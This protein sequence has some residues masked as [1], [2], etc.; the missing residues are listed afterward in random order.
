MVGQGRPV[1]TTVHEHAGEFTA[2][3]SVNNE[4]D[5]QDRQGV[6]SN[7]AGTF[8]HQYYQQ[9]GHDQVCLVGIAG[10]F[11]YA[12]IIMPDVEGDC[13]TEQGQ[14]PVNNRRFGVIGTFETGIHQ[15]AHGGDHR[16]M[17]RPVHQGYRWSEGG[18]VQ[19]ITRNQQAED[20]EELCHAP[21]KLAGGRFFVQFFYDFLRLGF[22]FL[23]GLLVQKLMF[24]C[25]I[26][27]SSIIDVF[28]F[29]Q[30]TSFSQ[31]PD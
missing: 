8:Q 28:L 5:G 15:E 2:E 17:E 21:C 25:G 18:G 19:M 9:G 6:A 26:V 23:L 30:N 10:P 14:D 16:Y 1:I 4:D 7:T 22:Q 31:L 20:V 3:K 24:R 11:H 12:Q 27:V 13:K 29:H